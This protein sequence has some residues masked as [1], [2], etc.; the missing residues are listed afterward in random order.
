[1][2]SK[3]TII[4]VAFVFILAIVNVFAQGNK[5][6][7]TNHSNN[8]DIGKYQASKFLHNISKDRI[9]EQNLKSSMQ[10]LS[11]FDTICSENFDTG[12]PGWTFQ[13]L[14]SESF[15]HTSTTGAYSD[16]SYWCGIEELGGYDDYWVQT[17][18]SPEINLSGTSSPVLTF[19]H[20]F[21]VE[22]FLWTFYDF[23]AYDALTI[24]IS[25][26]G[27]NYTNINPVEGLEYTAQNAFGFYLRFGSG[28]PGWYGNSA[29]WVS[30][31]FNLEAYVGQTIWIQFL[32][33]SDYGYS[34]Q[35]DPA[36]FG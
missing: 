24:R 8:L 25:T 9:N 26:D 2:K 17:L 15:W 16:H 36:L 23:D 31:S 10:I 6:Q 4:S 13:D 1:M 34:S 14:W 35:D 3:S 12:A 21:N 33:G 18:T 11:D 7:T 28:M 22:P 32:F 30:S 20:H 27:E 29:G 5:V 19:M